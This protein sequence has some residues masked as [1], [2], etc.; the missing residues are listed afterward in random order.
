MNMHSHDYPNEPGHRGV[1]TS[2][3]AARAIELS[4]GHLQR[5]ALRAIRAAGGRGLTTNELAATARID[6]D[7]I[8]PRTTELKLLGLIR[9]SGGRRPNA[10]GIN[11]IVWVAE[12]KA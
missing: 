6:R 10:N 4:V 2:I 3:E 11:A 1:D 5:V 7:S 12:V 9:D 8:Q